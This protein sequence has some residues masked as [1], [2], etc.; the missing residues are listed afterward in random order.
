[1]YSIIITK[2]A[3]SDYSIAVT[4]DV[5]DIHSGCSVR[6]TLTEVLEELDTNSLNVLK[7]I[8]NTIKL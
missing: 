6:G 7:E 1:M 4:D 8:A 3:D 5:T 2:Y